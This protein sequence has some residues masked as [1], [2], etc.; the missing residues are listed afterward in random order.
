M[1]Y[2]ARLAGQSQGWLPL[3]LAATGYGPGVRRAVAVLRAQPPQQESPALLGPQLACPV[4][5]FVPPPSLAWP[6]C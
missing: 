5:S 2:Q 1:R 3:D 6:A 4:L